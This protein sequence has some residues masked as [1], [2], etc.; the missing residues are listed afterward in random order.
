TASPAVVAG[1]NSIQFLQFDGDGV[2]I[3]LCPGG[4]S[5]HC[6]TK[7]LHLRVGPVVAYDHRQL[8]HA[9]LSRGFEMQV[10]VDNLVAA[11]DQNGNSE[12]ILLDT[13]RHAIYGMIVFAQWA[14]VRPKACD[15]PIFHG[16]FY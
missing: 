16:N 5:V 15:R 13:G 8:S 10:T 7:R 9:E 12:S 11:A 6:Q 1:I 3:P 2:P 14:A 4:G